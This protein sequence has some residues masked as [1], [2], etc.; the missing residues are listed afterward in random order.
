MDDAIQ[1]EQRHDDLI[2]AHAVKCNVYKVNMQ[3]CVNMRGNW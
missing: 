3:Q 1:K 2:K